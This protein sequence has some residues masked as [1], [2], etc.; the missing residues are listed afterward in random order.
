MKK[1]LL[2]L[3][4]LCAVSAHIPAY[5]AELWVDGV[6]LSGGWYDANKVNPYAEDGD[7]NLCWAASAANLVAWWQDKYQVPS[8]TPTD[9]NSIWSTYKSSANADTGGDTHAAFQWWLTGVYVPLNEEE[10]ERSMFGQGSTSTLSA[11][12][13]Y[14][15]DLY[16]D[17]MY[18]SFN[19]DTWSWENHLQDFFCAGYRETADADSIISLITDGCGIG[20]GLSND[21]GTMRHAITL[22][23]LEYD[24]ETNSISRMWLTDSDDAQY[25]ELY[26][27]FEQDGLFSVEVETKN[28]K[29]YISS[30]DNI[31]YAEEDNV[32]IS[33]LFG[34]N[35]AVSDAWGIPRAVP[36]PAAA[37]L[38]LLAL[39]GFAVRRRRK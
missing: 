37:V 38:S 10:E 19:F 14:Y 33:Y 28:G 15:Y 22:W 18:G 9:V 7:N 32:Y 8:G 6:S 13:G 36:E 20:L 34:V 39:T 31:W 3:S 12:E 35:P 25:S 30:S 1:I 17:E 24:S 5:S 29:L 27:W 2:F 26:D 21:S 11:W 16:G 4:L 23:G